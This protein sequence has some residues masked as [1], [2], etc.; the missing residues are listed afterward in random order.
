[1]NKSLNK[2]NPLYITGFGGPAIHPLIQ[3]N[4]IP[5]ATRFGSRYGRGLE[6]W[7]LFSGSTRQWQ[8]LMGRKCA[9]LMD[10]GLWCCWLLKCSQW[11]WDVAFLFVGR[12]GCIQSSVGLCLSWK[13]GFFSCKC[14]SNLHHKIDK[15]DRFVLTKVYIVLKQISNP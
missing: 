2:L 6:R 7:W 10:G 15:W 5:G 4:A 11:T 9:V 12:G 8:K 14:C 13:R 1:M 3:K